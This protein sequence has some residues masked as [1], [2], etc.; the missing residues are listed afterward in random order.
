[1]GCLK[2]CWVL[3]ANVRRKKWTW[4]GKAGDET[5]DFEPQ[6]RHVEIAGNII[7][8]G[9]GDSCNWMEKY[10]NVEFHVFLL[11]ILL[12]YSRCSRISA[13]NLEA[14]SAHVFFKSSDGQGWECRKINYHVC[15]SLN[16]IYDFCG[17]RIKN[18]GFRKSL[19]FPRVLETII[20]KTA[21]FFQNMSF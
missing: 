10:R 11:K 15:I 7:G 17:S 20:M 16:P 21:W 6:L 12:P 4:A 1:M 5:K 2:C 19:T 14:V 8:W 18:N 13:T 3:F 9:G